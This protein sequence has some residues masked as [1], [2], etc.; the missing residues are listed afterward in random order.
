MPDAMKRFMPL[1]FWFLSGL[2]LPGLLFTACTQDKPKPKHRPPTTQQVRDLSVEM[3]SWDR[4]R[5]TDE[6]DKYLERQGWTMQAT[7][8]GLRYMLL[9]AGAGKT[10]VQPEQVVKVA[11]TVRLMD[12]SVCYSSEKDGPRSFKVG[13]DDVESGIH[14]GVQLMHV[15]DKM[16]FV[17]P[18]HLAHGFTGDNGKIPP[19]AALV[20]EVEVLSAETEK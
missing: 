5:Q 18:S 7:A 6:I 12:G 17:L 4:Q 14:E 8:S 9:K 20:C 10:L 19:L 16:R 15:G 3:H 1:L 2:V 11:Y 13:H